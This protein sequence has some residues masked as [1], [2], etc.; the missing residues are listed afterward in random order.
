MN[1]TYQCAFTASTKPSS[2]LKVHYE[3][4]PARERFYDI[5]ADHV[6][7]K[8]DGIDENELRKAVTYMRS[9]NEEEHERNIENMV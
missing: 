2:V 6:V 1:V 7:E 9:E 5:M 3:P 4:S 8:N